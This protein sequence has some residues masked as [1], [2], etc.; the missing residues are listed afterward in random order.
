MKK[1]IV[2]G[3]IIFVVAAIICPDPSPVT[4]SFFASPMLALYFVGVAAANSFGPVMRFAYGA[5]YA[6]RRLSTK[7]AKS[8]RREPVPVAAPVAA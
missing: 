6:A 1:R 4:M 5:G 7:L 2:I 3:A 8:V